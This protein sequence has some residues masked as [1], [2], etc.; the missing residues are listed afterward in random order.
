MIPAE[1]LTSPFAQ[2]SAIDPVPTFLRFVVALLLGMVVA[3]VYRHTRGDTAIAPSFPATLMLLCVLIA[4]VTQVIGDNAARAFSLVGALSIVRFRTVVRDTQDTAFVM[5]S[6]ITGMAVGSHNLW[7]AVLGIIVVGSAALWSKLNIIPDAPPVYILVIRTLVSQKVE[8]LAG[9]IL[10]MHLV[11]RRLIAVGTPRK[12][13][14]ME[15]TYEARLKGEG[16]A[17]DLMTELHAVEGIQG[18]QLRRQDCEE[19]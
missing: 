7:V 8:L 3:A 4:I 11:D 2:I 15:Y 16:N 12:G 5:F 17:V 13:G 19:F 18:A 10:D 9:G 14:T 1:L 6:V